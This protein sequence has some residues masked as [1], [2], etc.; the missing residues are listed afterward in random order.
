MG[1]CGGKIKED[2]KPLESKVE[3]PIEPVVNQ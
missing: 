1:G 2:N 3:Q